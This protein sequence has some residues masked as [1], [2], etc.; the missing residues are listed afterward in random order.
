MNKKLKAT[1]MIVACV[2]VLIIVG[3]TF[4]Q[5]NASSNDPGTIS[6]PLVSKSYVD[7]KMAE[8]LTQVDAMRE[9]GD[10]NDSSNSSNNTVYMSELY[11]Y[12][13][14]QFEAINQEGIDISS[15][16]EVLQV[17]AGSRLICEEST[18]VIVRSG[19][20]SAIANS[21]GNG[22]SDVTAGIDI[23]QGQN[24]PTNH[25]I[26]IPR[27]DGRGLLVEQT[28]YVMVKGTYIIE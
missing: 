19:Q 2:S 13:D 6:D 1:L 18:E 21:A 24:V 15:K 25:L 14:D 27:T 11:D 8:L 5:L 12:I 22:L 7:S 9:S 28:C 26:I 23:S 4:D 20:V 10:S 3:L 16:F 17:Q